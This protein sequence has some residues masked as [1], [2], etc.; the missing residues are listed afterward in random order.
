M[1]MSP[2]TRDNYIRNMKMNIMAIESI[3][4]EYK[5][6]QAN[7]SDANIRAFKDIKDICE[8]QIN[9]KSSGSHTKKV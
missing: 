7:F 1:K 8:R 3:I 4:A 6:D 9:M 2:E 5:R